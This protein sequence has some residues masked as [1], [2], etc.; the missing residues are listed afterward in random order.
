MKSIWTDTVEL[1]HFSK[2]E[3]TNKT[4]VLIIGGGITGILCAYELQQ[5]GV[6]YCLVEA[7]T[8]CSGIT[9]N[10]TAKI[11]SQHGLIYSKLIEEYGIDAAFLYLKA[12]ELAIEHYRSL[13][14]DISCDFEN[15]NSYVYSINNPKVLEKELDA[16]NQI[17]Y[18]AEFVTKPEIPMSTAGAVKFS[19][20]AQFNPLKFISGIAR[21]LKIFEHTKVTELGVHTAKTETGEIQAGQ[22]I[23][24]THFPINNKH[25]MF[26]LKMHQSRSY[27]LALENAVLVDGM[28]V[29]EEKHGLSFR[30][31][32]NLLLLGGGGHRTGVN[33]G[34]YSE[35]ESYSRL[36]YPDS[37]IK[38]RYAAQDC[39]TLDA[40]PYIGPYSGGTKDFYAATGFNKWGM[41]TSMVSAIVLREYILG[42]ESEY[43]KVFNPN[44]TIWHPQLLLNSVSAVKNLLTFSKKRCPHM[45]CALK[46][47]KE[48]HTWDCP[49]HGSRFEENGELIDNPATGDLKV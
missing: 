31:Y 18:D 32:G 24:A 25:G 3:G 38:Y 5:A 45:G 7:D 37:K 26:F 27:V 35:V 29:D 9:K 16:L 1:P 15:K 21:Q 14:E 44:R 23:V 42:K 43:A 33:G 19:N 22:I 20:Q 4:D 49:C 46:W 13:C 12:N 17:G 6:D 2:L 47:N 40:V 39:M 10:T 28:Y 36:F 41:T 48:E 8:I 11:T 34:G 30:N